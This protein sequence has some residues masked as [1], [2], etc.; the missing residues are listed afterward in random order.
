MGIETRYTDFKIPLFYRRIPSR[1][2]LKQKSDRQGGLFDFGRIPSRWE[3]KLALIFATHVGV[4]FRRIP[5]RWELKHTAAGGSVFGVTKVEFH[6]V[7]N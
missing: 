6:P 7:G 1:W 4:V 2:E 5:S 3:L